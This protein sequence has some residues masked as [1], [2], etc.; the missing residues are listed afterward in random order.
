MFCKRYLIFS[1]RHFFFCTFQSFSCRKLCV[2]GHKFESESRKQELWEAVNSKWAASGTDFNSSSYVHC[3]CWSEEAWVPW[4][5]QALKTGAIILHQERESLLSLCSLRTVSLS[6]N[7]CHYQGVLS[8]S[9]L[10]PTE[11][12]SPSISQRPMCLSVVVAKGSPYHHWGAPANI[13]PCPIHPAMNSW[14]AVD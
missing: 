9:N 4:V 7:R 3:G 11:Q 1:K 8:G 6:V 2:P 14:K 10:L 12:H 5:Q 13:V